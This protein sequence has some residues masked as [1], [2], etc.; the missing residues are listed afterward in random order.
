MTIKVQKVCSCSDDMNEII[1]QVRKRAK[2]D[3]IKR[4]NE[5]RAGELNT[6]GKTAR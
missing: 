4:K 3:F 2:D 1:E 5:G 6:N